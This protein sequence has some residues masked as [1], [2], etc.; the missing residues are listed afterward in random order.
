MDE[1]SGCNKMAFRCQEETVG[2][3]NTY[4]TNV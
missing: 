4:L 2:N 1:V 3:R